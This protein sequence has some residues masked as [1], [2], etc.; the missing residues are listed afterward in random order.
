MGPFHRKSQARKYTWCIDYRWWL[1]FGGACD[2]LLYVR[3]LIIF[4]HHHKDKRKSIPRNCIYSF[5]GARAH[6]SVSARVEVEPNYREKWRVEEGVT[7][8]DWKYWGVG[9]EKRHTATMLSTF[10]LYSKSVAHIVHLHGR[11][12][13]S[14]WLP[15]TQYAKKGPG[16]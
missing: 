4:N 5:S 8:H 1:R 11:I 2:V 16:C 9:M 10:R 3:A 7:N 15:C 14:R 13:E 6:A 12:H